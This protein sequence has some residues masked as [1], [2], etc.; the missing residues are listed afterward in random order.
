MQDGLQSLV[1][2]TSTSKNPR[3]FLRWKQGRLYLRRVPT[4]RS[5]ISAAEVE[6]ESFHGI[7]SRIV[8]LNG[9]RFPSHIVCSIVRQTKCL[10]GSPFL[11]VRMMYCHRED[12]VSW[13]CMT[14]REIKCIHPNIGIRG[15]N[16][17]NPNRST[18]ISQRV[19]A[20]GAIPRGREPK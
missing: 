17:S 20:L 10:P 14:C 3:P 8:M 5:G 11:Q 4:G 6:A 18:E 16:G 2:G 12:R 7:R 9:S 1:N 13:C 15:K 19:D